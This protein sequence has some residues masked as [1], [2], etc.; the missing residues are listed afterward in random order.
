MP[1]GS[2]TRD[3]QNEWSPARRFP[4]GLTHIAFGASFARVMPF[5]R[6]PPPSCAAPHQRE[7]M[8]LHKLIVVI[9]G[10]IAL[11]CIVAGII[12]ITLNSKS[13]SGRHKLPLTVRTHA[14]I[15]SEG[16]DS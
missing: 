3:N 9:I 16:G 1:G 2:P 13:E 11:C 12:A 10:F 8:P 15:T 7:A 5:D 6:N 14:S 4:Y